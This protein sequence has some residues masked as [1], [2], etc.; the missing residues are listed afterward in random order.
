MRRSPRCVMLAL[1][2]LSLAG[3]V[4]AAEPAKAPTAK[5]QPAKEQPLQ[6]FALG[7]DG[8]WDYLTLDAA[9]HRLYIARATRVMVVDAT[10]GKLLGELPD[11]PGV[12]GV[13]LV[14]ESGRGF[15][16]SG[17]DNSV[18]VFDLKTLKALGKV[19][20]GQNPDAILYDPA[21]HRVFVFNGKSHDASVIDPAKQEV[22]AT[23]P[24]DGKPEFAV[25]DGAGRIYVNI[26]DKAQLVAID[27][28]KAE[29]V[30]RW[31]LA[32]C[33]EPT[34]LALDK[35]NHRL[36]S[37]CSNKV[38]TVVDA[39]SGKLVTTLP[40]GDG[41]DGVAFDPQKHLAFSSNGQDGTLTV[42]RQ[43]TPDRYSVAKTIPT[44]KG[45]RTLTLDPETHKVY[46]VTARFG[47]TPAPTAAQP[48]P[49]PALE[50]NSFELLV[51][52]PE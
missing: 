7:G 42:I 33:E 32:P 45:A 12:H 23:I 17:R 37:G 25:A 20:V 38:M 51:V 4:S 39:E 3:I 43:E 26:E 28:R 11:T 1:V 2:S 13:A 18:T 21:L 41:V 19:K 22:V 9:T 46:L 27:G 49:R 44:A 35:A 52:T 29:V 30:A 31:S 50:P 8:G 15:V 5:E 48:R 36:F 16:S 24:L 47:A 6:H 10:N 40:I 14:P 34:G